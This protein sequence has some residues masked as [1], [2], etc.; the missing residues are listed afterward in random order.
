M[1]DEVA[2]L[3]ERISELEEELLQ[4]RSSLAPVKNPF[5]K[6]LG[7]S[8]QQSAL[9]LGLYKVDFARYDYLDAITD[10]TGKYNRMTDGPHVGN[11]T[12]VAVFKL[13]RKLKKYGVD[14]HMCWGE[15]Y[16]LDKTN[17]AK[18]DKLMKGR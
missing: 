10:V 3:R 4:L 11:R 13:R 7:N 9:L 8:P 1:K 16:Y 6:I 5:A 15:G 12:K 14:I 18:L 2:A 17:K